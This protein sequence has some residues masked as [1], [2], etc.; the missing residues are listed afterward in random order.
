MSD[1]FIPK[2]KEEFLEG[3]DL[4]VA[5]IN[6]RQLLDAVE[7]VKDM[8]KELKAGYHAMNVAHSAPAGRT[9]VVV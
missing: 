6:N 5:R 7:A 8:S 4:G 2:S 9:A 1:L 3:V